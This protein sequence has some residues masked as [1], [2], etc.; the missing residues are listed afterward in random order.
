[1]RPEAAA[2]VQGAAESTA[3]CFPARVQKSTFLGRIS[4]VDVDLGGQPFT[5][6]LQ[7]RAALGVRPG[8]EVAVHIPPE[9]I[10]VLA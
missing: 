4:R 3:N 2:I 1:V 5:L 6:E 7:S 8:Q 10:L 9:A